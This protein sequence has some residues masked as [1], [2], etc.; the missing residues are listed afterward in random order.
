MLTDNINSNIPKRKREYYQ[1]SFF[2]DVINYEKRIIMN[3]ES[4]MT[5]EEQALD[6]N[7][8]GCGSNYFE[9]AEEEKEA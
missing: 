3:K 7:C 5:L 9:G 1:F 8:P 6:N 2:R 4:G